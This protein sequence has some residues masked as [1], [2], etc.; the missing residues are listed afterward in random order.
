VQGTGDLAER[1][2]LAA[3]AA[4]LGVADRVRFGVV[5]RAGLVERYRAAD[6]LVFPS[7]WEEPFG[8]VPLEA[9]GVGRPVVSTAR[10]GS[11][12]YLAHG[13]NALVIPPSD[14]DALAA[15]V[16]RLAAD[17]ELRH[18]LRQ[19]GL[20]TAG[21]HT[22][23]GFASRTVEEIEATAA[24]GRPLRSRRTAPRP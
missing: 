1:G 8:L 3:L 15:A 12:E 19:G 22:L 21:A 13:A 17:D 24:G 23:D 16:Q 18:R 14:P 11:A 7:E 20:R 10:G 9:M 4:E 6:A 5:D 2:R